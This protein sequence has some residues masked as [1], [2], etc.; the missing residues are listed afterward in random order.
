MQE[1]KKMRVRVNMQV[2]S[3][4]LVRFPNVHNSQELNL[5]RLCDCKTELF[6][7]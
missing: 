4:P 2:L 3:N 6:E 1:I 5:G 7:P